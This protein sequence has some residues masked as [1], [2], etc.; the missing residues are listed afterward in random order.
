LR[1]QQC[2]P[3]LSEELAFLGQISR[4]GREDLFELIKDDQAMP[5]PIMAP[6]WLTRTIGKGSR[7]RDI[8]AGVRAA[9]ISEVL[10]APE[11]EYSSTMR[12]A[13]S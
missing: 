11:G 9:R 2:L 1:V 13:S 7:P 5:A 8:K 6:A 12:S 10:P 4:I 3:K